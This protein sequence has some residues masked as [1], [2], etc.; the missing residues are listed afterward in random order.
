MGAGRLDPGVAYATALKEFNE[1]PVAI[2][3]AVL[4]AAQK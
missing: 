4:L 1:L 3:E 2:D